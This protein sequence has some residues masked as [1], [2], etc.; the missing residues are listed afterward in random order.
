MA[1]VAGVTAT[2]AKRFETVGRDFPGVSLSFEGR[3]KDTRESFGSLAYLFPLALI[4]VYAIIA[5]LF[6]SYVQPV[7]VMAAIPFGLVGAVLG[8]LIMGYPFTILSTIGAVALTGILVNDS[9]ILVDLINRLRSDGLELREAIVRGARERMR[10]I[11]LTSIT[12]IA[13]L[14]P[15]MLE[16][17]FQAQFLI[18]MAVSIV[19]G[20]AVATV[21]TL[22]LLPTIYLV[23]EDLKACAARSG[24]LLAACVHWMLTGRWEPTVSR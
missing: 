21:L 9:L 3:Q 10:P 4:I 11:L 16:T 13:G 24:R 1:N 18:P 20:L 6:R 23:F 15:L 17:S 5:I 14:S 22:I 2:L 7:V 19:F 12:T 8:H